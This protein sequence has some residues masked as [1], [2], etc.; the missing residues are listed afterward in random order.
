MEL[1][2]LPEWLQNLVRLCGCGDQREV[3][4][5]NRLNAR[6]TP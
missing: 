5:G 1:C 4:N 2:T 6:S 3:G